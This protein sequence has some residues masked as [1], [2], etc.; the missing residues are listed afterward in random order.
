V[1]FIADH[2]TTIELTSHVHPGKKTIQA[3]HYF[4]AAGTEMQRSQQ[5]LLQ[6]L[7]YDIFRQCPHLISIACAHRISDTQDHETPWTIEELQKVLTTLSSDSCSSVAFTIFVDGLDEYDGDH[8]VLCTTFK[9]LAECSHFKLCVS[10]RPWNVFEEAFGHAEKSKLYMQDLTKDDIRSYVQSRLEE[11]PRWHVVA[12]KPGWAAK[13][14]QEIVDISC[15]VFLW[16]Y[17]VAEMLR[18]GLTNRDSSSDMRRRLESFPPELEDFFQ[19]ILESVEGFYHNKMSSALQLAAAAHEPLHWT[20][21]AFHEQEYDDEDYALRVPNEAFKD[22]EL[23]ELRLDTI[24]QINS[25][26]QGL[27]EATSSGL[28]TFLH[29]TVKDYMDTKRMSDFL[30]SKAVS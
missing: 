3:S 1:K 14:I 23:K 19:R 7:L 10:S 17:L 11:H 24:A 16:V 30:A 13:L 6:E 8:E 21:Y 9:T 22:Q 12:S 27:L 2:P 4:W 28:V 5:G 29:R 25:R 18:K 20:V 26:T 15:G